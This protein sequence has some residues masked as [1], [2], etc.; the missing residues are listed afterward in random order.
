MS[1]LASPPTSCQALTPAGSPVRDS[2]ESHGPDGAPGYQHV[3]R[4]ASSLVRLRGSLFLTEQQVD[5]LVE[6]WR[7]LADGDKQCLILRDYSQVRELVLG[8]PRLMEKTTLQLFQLNQHTLSQWHNKRQKGQKQAV[9]QLGVEPSSA[10]AVDP[11]PQPQ[12]HPLL[13]EGVT[14]SHQL[15]AIPCPPNTVGEAKQ[16]KLP[17]ATAQTAVLVPSAIPAPH[18]TSS[19]VAAAPPPHVS[20]TTCWRHR[21]R[22]EEEVGGSN[23]GKRK[24][25]RKRAENLCS[26][27]GQPKQKEFGQSRFGNVAFCSASS[28][29]TV[30]QWL[31]EMRAKKK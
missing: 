17:G 3:Q 31:T 13:Q 23:T 2:E 28:G 4:L 18:S 26:L 19:A 7:L 29:K 25:E 30:A 5:E 9:L 22:A 20:S 27:C 1:P 8:S 16:Q 11:E 6:L 24:Y 12:P 14:Y 15:H 21:K 10:S